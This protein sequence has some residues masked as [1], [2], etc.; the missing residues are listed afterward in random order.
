LSAVL[1]RQV[2]VKYLAKWNPTLKGAFFHL[3]GR[4][5]TFDEEVEQKA[6]MLAYFSATK[7]DFS[8]LK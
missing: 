7:P 8:G 1:A 4:M 3:L 6:T 2:G 5:V